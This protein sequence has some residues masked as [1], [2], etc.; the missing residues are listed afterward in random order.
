MFNSISKKQK[1]EALT[2]GL[3]TEYIMYGIYVHLNK[4]FF[5]YILNTAELFC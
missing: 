4:N 5:Y 3:H 2:P 1:G